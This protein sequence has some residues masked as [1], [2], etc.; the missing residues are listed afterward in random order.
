MV[1]KFNGRQLATVKEAKLKEKVSLLKQKGITPYIVHLGI[2]RSNHRDP[3][4]PGKSGDDLQ[5]KLPEWPNDQVHL[6]KFR[7]L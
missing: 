3:V 5:V 7:L 1:K 2:K 4:F 6:A